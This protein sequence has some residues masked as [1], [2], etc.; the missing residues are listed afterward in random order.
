MIALL[1]I[2]FSIGLDTLAVAIG[3]GVAQVPRERWLR[4][5]VTFACF[6]GGMPIL[7]MLVGRQS[8]GVFGQWASLIAALI[9]IA[10]G[11]HAIIESF[12]EPDDERALS[13]TNGWRLLLLGLT[14]SLDEA[15]LGFSL[16]VI[17]GH[18]GIAL[19]FIIAQAVVLTILGLWIGRRA[20][21]WLGSRAEFASGAI[22]VLLGIVLAIGRFVG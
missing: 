3:L 4:L 17:G 16:G 18:L 11:V 15:A 8:A 14:V 13:T 21:A 9:L 2:L 22:L 7:G 1:A 6:E 5:A 12:S 10:L 20:G 19:A